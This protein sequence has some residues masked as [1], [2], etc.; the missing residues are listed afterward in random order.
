MSTASLN[1][2]MKSIFVKDGYEWTKIMLNE[3]LYVEAS[4]NYLTFHQAKKKIT[5]KMTL[6]QAEQKLPPEYFLRVHKSFIVNF[7]KL[8]KM[9][10]SQVIINQTSIPV[11]GTYRNA[12]L[13]RF[14]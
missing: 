10:G 7:S 4:D 11:S 14:K 12:L 3:L 1:G 2:T 5:V 6:T 9:D 13:G 8:E